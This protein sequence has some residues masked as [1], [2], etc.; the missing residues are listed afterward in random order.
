MNRESNKKTGPMVNPTKSKPARV[1]GAP[2]TKKGPPP[3]PPFFPTDDGRTDG[4]NDLKIYLLL[5]EAC[6]LQ[7]RTVKFVNI[8]LKSILPKFDEDRIK[9]SGANVDLHIKN[10]SDIERAMNFILDIYKK[11]D[12]KAKGLIIHMATIWNQIEKNKENK[13][14]IENEADK[15]ALDR[16]TLN[17]TLYTNHQTGNIETI[18]VEMILQA[19]FDY[20]TGISTKF[21]FPELYSLL[22]TEY[23]VSAEKYRFSVVMPE[24]LNDGIKLVNDLKTRM[25]SSN[26]LTKLQDTLDTL[27]LKEYVPFDIK[28]KECDEVFHCRHDD[29]GVGYRTCNLDYVDHMKHKHIIC[30][31]CNLPCGEEEDISCQEH[32]RSQHETEYL[33]S[34]PKI[35]GREYI[36][37]MLQKTKPDRGIRCIHCDSFNNRLK[38]RLQSKYFCIKSPNNS[39]FEVKTTV[40]MLFAAHFAFLRTDSSRC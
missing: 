6:H 38:D 8:I 28:C 4:G 5:Y 29:N 20:Y 12:A 23:Y 10:N 13:W 15:E 19:L 36:H 2:I 24:I 37:S 7:Q 11:I 3:P 30:D 1:K 26:V 27:N 16:I 25:P 9:F 35:S 31:L 34:T 33:G 32:W 39:F 40:F 14:I 21:T 22:N 18:N 17:I